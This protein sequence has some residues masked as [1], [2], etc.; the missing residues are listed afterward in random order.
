M[1]TSDNAKQYFVGT[2]SYTKVG[3]VWLFVWLLWGDFCFTLM[4]AVIP[5][6]VPL[7]LKELGAPNWLMAW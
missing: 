1:Q 3:L 4:E 2:L 6:I 7:K 5:S